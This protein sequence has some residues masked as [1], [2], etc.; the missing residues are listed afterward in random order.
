MQISLPRSMQLDFFLSALWRD[1]RCEI[2][3]LIGLIQTSDI[4][5]FHVPG[6]PS[7]LYL[8]FLSLARSFAGILCREPEAHFWCCWLRKS[9]N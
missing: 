3:R 1:V 8:L 5:L 7:L 2:S 9:A 4:C 6:A